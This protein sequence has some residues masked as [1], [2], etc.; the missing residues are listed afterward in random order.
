MAQKVWI[1]RDLGKQVACEHLVDEPLGAECSCSVASAANSK[2]HRDKAKTE[3]L[4]A[5]QSLLN[6]YAAMGECITGAT[7][8]E[9]NAAIYRNAQILLSVQTII[10]NIRTGL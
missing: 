4:S 7:T 9:E 2:Q 8:V 3:L 5:Y 1:H 6:A 10:W